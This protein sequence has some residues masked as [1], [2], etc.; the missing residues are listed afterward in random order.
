[1]THKNEGEEKAHAEAVA[2]AGRIHRHESRGMVLVAE[3]SAE[4]REG[5][6]NQ[7]EGRGVREHESHAWR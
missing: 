7:A 6:K 4:R 5:T 1:M 3:L 2:A